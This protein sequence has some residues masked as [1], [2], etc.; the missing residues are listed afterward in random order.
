MKKIL[1]TLLSAVLMLM[2]CIPA[3]AAENKGSSDDA[4]P[5][6]GSWKLLIVYEN[7]KGKPPVLLKQEDAPSVYGSGVSVYT[8]DEDG[9]FHYT[10]SDEPGSVDPYGTWTSA[11]SDDYVVTEKESADE[12]TFAYEKMNGAET[13][14]RVLKDDDPDAV[15]NDLTL[16]FNRAFVGS[17]TLD[18]VL[19]ISENGDPAELS[20]EDNQSLYGSGETVLSI[21]ADCTGQSISSQAGSSFESSGTWTMTGQDQIIYT[22]DA[23]TLD[24]QYYSTDD[25][26][27]RVYSD[28]SPDAQY[29]Q[30]QFIYVRTK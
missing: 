22:E 2:M 5:V 9:T 12:L 7:L 21:K 30:L 16:V 28:D 23:M 10:V 8:F 14:K 15:Y 3:L 29:A 20:R 27:I 25:T 13:L 4:D 19:E 24:L 11:G 17:W 6:V 26:L 18:R 1:I